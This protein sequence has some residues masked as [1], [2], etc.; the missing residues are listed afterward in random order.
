MSI[1]KLGPIQLEFSREDE[2]LTII[3]GLMRHVNNKEVAG[4]LGISERTVRRWKLAGRLPN[5]EH[6]QISLLELMMHLM[7]IDGG[8]GGLALGQLMPPDLKA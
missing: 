6:E 3:Q 8:G 1:L 2:A 7:R 4:M 5:K